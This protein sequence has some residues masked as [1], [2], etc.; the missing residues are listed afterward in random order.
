ME[1]LTFVVA[2]LFSLAGV[3]CIL[4]VIIGL[5]G[6]WMLLGLALIVEIMDRWYLPV[7]DR[8]TFNWWV[9]AACVLLAA[10]GEL[11]ELFAGM[12]GAKKAGSTRRGMFGSLIGGILGA[13]LGLSIP[14]PLVGPLIGAL[15][16]TFVGAVVGELSAAEKEIH[17]TLRPATGATIGRILGTLSK[18]PVAVIVWLWLCVSAFWR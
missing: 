16:G 11:F 5:P 10:L 15:I 17:Q 3:L 6:T 9:L 2:A 14:M 13:V 8:Q 1:W 18:L 7:A 4:A 12:L